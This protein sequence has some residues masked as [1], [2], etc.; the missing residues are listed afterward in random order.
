MMEVRYYIG[1]FTDIN[2]IFISYEEKEFLEKNSNYLMN[3]STLSIFYYNTIRNLDKLIDYLA[4]KRNL[5][6]LNDYDRK[7]VFA[8]YNLHLSNTVASFYSL[9]EFIESMYSSTNILSRI[10]DKHFEYRLFY[11]FRKIITHEGLIVKN[12]R[13]QFNQD[14]LVVSAIIKKEDIINSKK[15]NK[16]FKKELEQGETKELDLFVLCGNF[17]KVLE[18]LLENLISNEKQNIINSFTTMTNY[19]KKVGDKNEDCFMLKNDEPIWSL[20]KVTNMFLE[21]YYFNFLNGI[22]S[23]ELVK[24]STTVKSLFIQLSFIYFGTPGAIPKFVREF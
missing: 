19:M 15:C 18:D 1:S 7:N 13:T 2:K 21:R 24:E 12:S 5:N 4:Q 3:L 20:V 14:S 11:E 17:K 10:Y 8:D 22:N 6:S 16:K 23:H 9:I